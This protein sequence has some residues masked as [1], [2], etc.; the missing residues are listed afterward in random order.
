M[1]YIS[2]A[3]QP[4]SKNLFAAKAHGRESAESTAEVELA[5]YRALHY[6]NHN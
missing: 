4:W 6:N 5:H 1:F 3:R 2:M